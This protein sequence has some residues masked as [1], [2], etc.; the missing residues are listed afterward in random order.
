MNRVLI[1]DDDEELCE[2]VS[3]YLTAEDFETTCVHDGVKGLER[4]RSGEFDLAILDVMLPKMN[5]FEL[6]SQLRKSSTL[7]VLMLTARGEDI[8][9]IGGLESGADDYLPKPF[10]PREL[11]ARLRAILRRISPDDDQAIAEK[12]NVDDL[13][14]S[15][16][17]RSLKRGGEEVALT[18]V[19]FELLAALLQDAGTI[20][21]KEDLS[22]T[23]LE[24]RLSPYDRS[25][26]MHI[27]NL[28][29]K[30]GP[31]KDGGERI[32]TVRSVGYIYTI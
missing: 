5:G 7:P 25:L 16:T 30:L 12:I 17:S 1:I 9:R 6:L 27:S 15:R 31:R 3:E 28:R 14:L 20:L 22:E 24:R 2:L 11:V 26:D 8:D 18:S 19:E 23:V 4:A 29:K 13:E 32:K 10:N 21:R